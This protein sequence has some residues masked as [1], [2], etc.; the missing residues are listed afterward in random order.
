MTDTT[1]P[2]AKRSKWPYIILGC[3]AGLIVVLCGVGIIAS[4][5]NSTEDKRTPESI[6]GSS[7][8]PKPTTTSKPASPEV[9][10]TL[11]TFESG[12]TLLV[13]QEIKPGT[14][15]ALV[16]A[17]SYCYWERLKDTSGSL[18][19][20]IA[21]NN[22]EAGKKATVTISAHDKAFNSR[23]CGTWVRIG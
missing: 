19:A 20:I 22:V 3:L 11:V 16:P 8:A 7:L 14:Y 15:R 4:V 2:P 9:A 23:D 18:D 6:L 5:G 10:S 1:V 21:N 12:S 13:P 17:D